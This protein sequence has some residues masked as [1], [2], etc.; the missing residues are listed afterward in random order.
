MAAHPGQ[1]RPASSASQ[2][3]QSTGGGQAAWRLAQNRGSCNIVKEQNELG[4]E[5]ST[6]CVLA[7]Q[8]STPPSLAPS[9]ATK[10]SLSAP[11]A[12]ACRRCLRWGEALKLRI[13]PAAL[14]A[15]A[16]SDNELAHISSLTGGGKLQGKRHKM[17]CWG[18]SAAP[19]APG[20]AMRPRLPPEP[21]SA[22][23][24][25]PCLVA[26][27][28]PLP[29]RSILPALL[30]I[31]SSSPKDTSAALTAAMTSSSL[32]TSHCTAIASPPTP[33]PLASSTPL[34]EGRPDA[35]RELLGRLAE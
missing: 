5:Y 29:S 20:E 31:T 19:P 22:P 26:L 2:P 13:D 23:Y 3:P 16:L 24:V 30:H 27:R 6:K 11:P 8:H 12:P 32:D 25:R 4:L 21:A 1:R 28:A 34:R 14:W 35:V 15:H 10:R 17:R 33:R 18:A 9:P 7:A